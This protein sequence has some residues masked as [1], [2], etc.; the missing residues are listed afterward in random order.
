MRS[1]TGALLLTGFLW[2]AAACAEELSVPVEYHGKQI[3][4]TG[5]FEKAALQGPLPVVIL[6]HNCAGID[7]SPSLA[8]SRLGTVDMGARIRHFAAR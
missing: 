3:Q 7:G 6:L 5:R 2:S 8:P 4:L 1:H